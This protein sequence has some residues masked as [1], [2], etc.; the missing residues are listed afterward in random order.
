MESGALEQGKDRGRS[1]VLGR[2]WD[3]EGGE[4]LVGFTER[5]V[6][7]VKMV[8]PKVRRGERTLWVY[9]G[10]AMGLNVLSKHE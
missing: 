9:Y 7:G 1:H 2:K 8:V 3:M 4:V 6:I 5:C 10:V